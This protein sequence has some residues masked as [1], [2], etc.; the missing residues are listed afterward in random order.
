MYTARPQRTYPPTWRIIAAFLIVPGAT[1][2]LM[3]ILMPAFDGISDPLDRVWRSAVLFALF[4]AYPTT[5]ILGIPAFFVLRRHFYP[6]LINCSLTGAVV[7]ALP[8]FI[9]SVLSHSGSASIGGRATVINGS[10]TAYGWLT[11]LIF[12]GQIAT[13]GAVGGSLFWLIA[14]AGNGD[15]RSDN[16]KDSGGPKLR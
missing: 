11:N 10:L 12:V 9:L 13:L 3:A 15:G 7:A 14:A 16:G 5:V 2:L 8:W 4:G 1:A 6:K